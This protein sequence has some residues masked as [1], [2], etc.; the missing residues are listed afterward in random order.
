VTGRKHKVNAT[1]GCGLEDPLRDYSMS[2]KY[3]N[4]GGEQK[5]K[6]RVEV[7]VRGKEIYGPSG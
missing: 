2:M 4:G 7:G 6:I 5:R 3:E 1:K